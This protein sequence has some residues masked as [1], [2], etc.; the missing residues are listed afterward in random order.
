MKVQTSILTGVLA[1]TALVAALAGQA[2][3]QSPE[4]RKPWCGTNSDGAMNCVYTTVSECEKW[5]SADGWCVPNP[6]SGSGN[7]S[8]R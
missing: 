5:M 7:S 2:Q 3:A 1:A 8:R 4:V 6:R